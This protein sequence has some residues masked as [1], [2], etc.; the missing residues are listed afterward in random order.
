MK[1]N[2]SRISFIV[3]QNKIFNV[4]D[5]LICGISGGQDSLILFVLI[6]HFKKIYKLKLN[7][8]YCNHFWQVKN[9][10]TGFEILKLSYL[11]NT[12]MSIVLIKTNLKSEEQGHF[13]RQKSF[14]QI[15]NYFEKSIFVL[16]HTLT[17]QIETSFWHLL[18]GTSPKGMISLKHINSVRS[19]TLSNILFN[20]SKYSKTKFQRKNKF[21]NKTFFY[22]SKRKIKKVEFL[23]FE[24]KNKANF[25]FDFTTYKIKDYQQLNTYYVYYFQIKKRYAYKITR[26]LLNFSRSSIKKLL[27]QNTLPVVTDNTNQSTKLI[28]NKIRLVIFPI[29]RHHIKSK[30]EIQIKTFI[31]ISNIEQT[32][33]NEISL[34]LI[35]NYLT[36]PELIYSLV[37]IPRSTKRICL[38]KLLQQYTFKQLKLL[39]IDK[40]DYTTTNFLSKKRKTF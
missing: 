30:C 20:L 17:D 29:I 7:N 1:K 16:G 34:T 14:L 10:Y 21:L 32:D 6:Y 40:V 31:N 8:I 2:I 23:N 37:T 11:S 33:L 22:Q 4:S 27:Q 12:P 28:R 39:F 26:P 15:G 24:P 5:N 9:F 18:R 13:W 19:N 25:L 38:S 3:H 36:D 35:L